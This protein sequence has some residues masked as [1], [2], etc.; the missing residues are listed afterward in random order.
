MILQRVH[1]G[2]FS[3]AGIFKQMGNAVCTENPIH[4]EDVTESPKL[5]E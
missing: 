1:D 5:A 4:V 2:K 3:R